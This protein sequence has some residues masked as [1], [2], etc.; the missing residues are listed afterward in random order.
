MHYKKWKT[1]SKKALVHI[2]L[3]KFTCKVKYKKSDISEIKKS[4]YPCT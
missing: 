3:Y 4:M 2:I 1:F